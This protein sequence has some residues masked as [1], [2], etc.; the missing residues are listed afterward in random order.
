MFINEGVYWGLSPND[1]RLREKSCS[2]SLFATTALWRIASQKFDSPIMWLFTLALLAAGANNPTLHLCNVVG[3]SPSL[4]SIRQWCISRRISREKKIF[5]NQQSWIHIFDNIDLVTGKSRQRVGHHS[6][7]FHGTVHVIVRNQ[8]SDITLE[9][10]PHQ[11]GISDDF[12]EVIVSSILPNANRPFDVRHSIFEIVNPTIIKTVGS[13]HRQ[14]LLWK[15][16]YYGQHNNKR[17]HL[18]RDTRPHSIR[19]KNPTVYDRSYFELLQILDTPCSGQEGVSAMIDKLR[20]MFGSTRLVEIIAADWAV[21]AS[22][23]KLAEEDHR[24]WNR[25]HIVPGDW[26]SGLHILKCIHLL[27]WPLIHAFKRKLGRTKVDLKCTNHNVC[28]DLIKQLSR[29]GWLSL[30]RAWE[31]SSDYNGKKNGKIG[32]NTATPAELDDWFRDWISTNAANDELF[33]Y[34]V[35][36]LELC[37]VLKEWHWA[38]NHGNSEYLEYAQ[39]WMIPILCQL[40]KRNY[41]KFFT[42]TCIDDLTRSHYIQDIYRKNRTVS[43][44]GRA[45]HNSSLDEVIEHTIKYVKTRCGS[46]TTIHALQSYAAIHSLARACL[47]IVD[48]STLDHH[49]SHKQPGNVKEIEVIQQCFDNIKCFSPLQNRKIG[50][51][52]TQQWTLKEP[53]G[54]STHACYICTWCHCGCI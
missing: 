23:R 9:H 33:R 15:Y 44:S 17:W 36:F 35:Q 20:T 41:A 45:C 11:I 3:L 38:I 28:Y 50:D 1:K 16:S 43:R 4:E 8:P 49:T 13:H 14:R 31:A 51:V 7:S 21:V 52:W 25:I 34:H 42:L 37:D 5:G 53:P 29:A 30:I 10:S 6:F 27:Y 48:P 18:S 54:T 32:N 40:G 19:E 39:R 22:L 12:Q 26:H 46:Q 2:Q 24:R 47:H